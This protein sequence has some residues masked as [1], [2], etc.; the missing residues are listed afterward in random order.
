ML[1]LDPRLPE[2]LVLLRPLQ[3]LADEEGGEGPGYG[4]PHQDTATAQTL[5]G[6]ADHCVEYFLTSSLD[7][8]FSLVSL[9]SN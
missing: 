4:Q 3:V 5:Q 8:F 2:C 6:G 7:L 9:L 1:H